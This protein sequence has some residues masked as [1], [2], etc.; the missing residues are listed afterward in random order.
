[1]IKT[2]SRVG[3]SSSEHK[4]GRFLTS[5]TLLVPGYTK[6]SDLRLSQVES[7]QHVQPLPQEI[8]LSLLVAAFH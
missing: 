1:V 6:S 2:I 4:Y 3:I 7:V 5:S 8:L